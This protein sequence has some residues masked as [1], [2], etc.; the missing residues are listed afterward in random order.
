MVILIDEYRLMVFPI[1]VGSGKR[2]FRDHNESKVLKHV[3]TQTFGS[4][5]AV[6]TY[7]PHR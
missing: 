7:Q 4:G 5:V 1:V 3:E 6:L 2:L